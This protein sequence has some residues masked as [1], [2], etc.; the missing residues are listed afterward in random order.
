MENYQL[1]EDPLTFDD[2]ANQLLEQ[3]TQYSPAHLHGAICG[4]VSGGGQRDPE[5]CLTAVMQALDIE[6]HGELAESC[7]KLAWMTVA[8]LADEELDFKLFM[9][10]DDDEVE[11]RVRALADWCS[12][13]LLGYTQALALPQGSKLDDVAS[14]VLRDM[15][16]IAEAA[17]DAGMEPEEA[18]SHYFEISEYLRIA[19]LNLFMDQLADWPID[20]E[21]E[22]DSE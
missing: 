16:A 13:F 18:E 3:G 19:T 9:P 1:D 17:V 5:Y 15:A 12:A 6:M 2:I 14:E 4:V 10:D 8:K 21:A 20:Q 22:Q 7:L 11:L